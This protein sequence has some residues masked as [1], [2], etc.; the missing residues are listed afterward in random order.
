LYSSKWRSAK[1]EDVILSRG[2]SP[3]P[4]AEGSLARFVNSK[5][6]FDSSAVGNRENEPVGFPTK[7]TEPSAKSLRKNFQKGIDKD[8]KIVYNKFR[9]SSNERNKNFHG[10]FRK[11]LDFIVNCNVII[12][13]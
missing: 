12:R 5:R 1:H 2:R 4:G 9:K 6:S 10:N 11:P 7:P 3:E 13:S 8:C